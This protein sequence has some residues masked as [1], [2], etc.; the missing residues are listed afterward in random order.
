MHKI[1]VFLPKIGVGPQKWMV[2]FHG[3]PGLTWD[4]LRGKPTILGTPI[5][6]IYESIKFQISSVGF[7]GAIC[8]TWSYW[9][10]GS[11]QAH[12]PS[13]RFEGLAECVFH[14]QIMKPISRIIMTNIH[15]HAYDKYAYK[16]IHLYILSIF[17]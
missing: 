10:S 7:A 2:N 8:T 3:K 13:S 17:C 1:W 11:S 16:Y 4:D 5:L 15:R 9:S 12:V 6:I 14:Y